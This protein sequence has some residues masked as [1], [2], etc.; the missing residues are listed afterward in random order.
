MTIKQEEISDAIKLIIKN[1]MDRIMENVLIKDPFIEEIFRAKKPLYSALVPKEIF[2][3]SHFERRFVTPFGRVWE[4][5]AEVAI[6]KGIGNCVLG[7][8]IVG[9]IPQERLRRITEVLNKLEHPNV[10]EVR[11][12]PIGKQ[13]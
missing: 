13:N 1:L 6:K 11:P 3:G 9:N 8:V 10:G 7:K 4:K 2:K 5:L 12:N